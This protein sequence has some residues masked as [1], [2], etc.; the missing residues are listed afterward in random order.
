MELI[1][2]NMQSDT[3][4]QKLPQSCD[5]WDYGS[6]L[7]GQIAAIYAFKNRIQT[8]KNICIILEIDFD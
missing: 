3:V 7:R 2:T 4:S 5:V 6:W 8:E 1:A